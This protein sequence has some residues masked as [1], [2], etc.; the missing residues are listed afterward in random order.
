MNRR[1]MLLTAGAAAAAALTLPRTLRA[2]DKAGFTLPPLPYGYDALEPIIDTE[3]MKIH[4][5]KHHKAYVDNLNKALAGHDDLLKMSIDELVQH[6][7]QIEDKKLQTAVVNNGG[8]HWNHSMFWQIMAP[9]GQG[10][11][12][13][14]NLGQA[15]QSAGGIDKLKS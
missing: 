11:E 14:G 8:G 7:K 10:G 5:D 12:P 3:T 2:D 15:I 6:V 4:H 1:E 9:K 13:S